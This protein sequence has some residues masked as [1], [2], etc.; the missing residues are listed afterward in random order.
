[1]MQLQIILL[2]SSLA[3]LTGC[4]DGTKSPEPTAPVSIRTG[5]TATIQVNLHEGG[6]AVDVV[7]AVFDDGERINLV[8][9]DVI[10]AVTATQDT[11]LAP[12]EVQ[13]GDYAGV[14]PLDE[15]NDV[16][17][18]SIQHRPV[19]SREDRWYPV[20]I[21][22]VDAE[23]SEYVGRSATV[24]IPTELDLLGPP[25]Q[26]IYTSRGDNI[27]ITW[28]PGGEGDSMRLSASVS[29]RNS[30]G[31]LSYGLTYD[32]GD[33]DGHYSIGMNKLAYNDTL[34][35][36]V[37]AFS[38]HI[39]RVLF[40]AVAEALTLGLVDAD[41]FERAPINIETAD[42]DIYLLLMREQIGELDA[43]FDGGQA[44]GS[45]SAATTILYRPNGS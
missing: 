45:T 26:A 17:T 3:I 22:M 19:A 20:D 16:I 42:C 28:V 44:I 8:G 18:V 39:S 33:D 35:S 12:V 13:N 23:P 25:E 2:S 24:L 5:L 7:A 32:M 9:G 10:E 6:E 27:D 29:C 30:Y 11:L 15:P 21:L 31:G 37:L 41:D 34:T 43:E 36:L 40:A 38:E 14:L 1:M 4:M